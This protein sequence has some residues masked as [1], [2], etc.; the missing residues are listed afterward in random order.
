M[1]LPI[2]S[3]FKSANKTQY[4]L[5]LLLRDEK[6]TAVI[7]EESLG[8]V[9]IISKHEE[10]FATP[11]E[12]ASEE[13]WLD[14]IDKTIS[15]AEEVLPPNIETQKTVFGVKDSW[16]EEKRIK[17]DYLLKLKKVCEALSLT[18]IGFLVISE[19]I[20]HLMQEEEGA[21]VSAVLTEIGK[22]S[23]MI[24]LIRGG[25]VVETSSV[26]RTEEV[27]LAV[28][29]AL[30]SFQ[31][32]VLPSR[33]VIFDGLE[34]EK[35]SQ[36][37]ISHQWSKSLPFLH[38]PQISILPPGFDAKAV[39]FGAAVQMGFTIVGDIVDKTGHEIKTLGHTGPLP[40]TEHPLVE[41]EPSPA[42]S[43]EQKTE[44]EETEP[45]DEV[46]E[47][48]SIAEGAETFGFLTDVDVATVK[49]PPPTIEEP[50]PQTTKHEEKQHAA[51]P[52]SDSLH[53][54]GAK[55]FEE[56]TKEEKQAI[57]THHHE[58]PQPSYQT[59]AGPKG[60]SKIASLLAG[61][62]LPKIALPKGN[63]VFIIPVLLVLLIG[64]GLAYVFLVRAAIT[65]TIKPEVVD[66]TETIVFS[67][68][69]DTDTENHT[70]G[71]KK[72]TVTLD[73]TAS[74]DATGKKDTGNKA[75]GNVTLYNSAETK[76]QLSQGATITS[77]NGL[78]FIVDKEVVVA[79]SSG[80]IFSGIKSGTAQV[81]VTAKAIG[82]EYNLPSNTKFTVAGISSL[83]AKNDTAFSGGSKKQV[84]VVA[85]SDIDKL[86]TGLPKSLEEKAKQEIAK[87]I[88]SDETVLPLFLNTTLAKK[89]FN[90][91]VGEETKTVTLKTQV[92]F[93]GIAYKNENLN[94]IAKSI[95]SDKSSENQAVSEKGVKNTLRSIK[96]KNEDE[97][98]ASLVVNAGLLPKIDTTKV[99]QDVKGKSFADAEEILSQMSQIDGVDIVL[100][101]NIPFLPKLLPRLEKN[102]KVTVQ[103]N[104]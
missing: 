83:A 97:V 28:D 95:I 30:K 19:A 29:A 64:I 25:K 13:E 98:S 10:Y 65:L 76:K 63:S 93:D 48:V 46:K 54:E 50:L 7:I 1:K 86:T 27:T 44:N 12:D 85:K 72:I 22:K 15:R 53:L 99:L 34:T 73:G 49:T 9:K 18:P 36:L 101:P 8:R 84:T 21:P 39:V 20:I 51:A 37:F 66:Q 35:L 102:I 91:D 104:E 5:S 78:D 2:P 57:A 32:D 90:K 70:V 61:I 24:S 88:G 74:T 42:K 58:E 55:T 96:E 43:E 52:I 17:K 26:P 14:I 82:S 79:S 67:T 31:T 56:V 47:T 62:S 11:I 89:S 59:A 92:T 77:S 38:M 69:S 80:D 68:K 81:A 33:V 41:N 4:F 60:P 6:A 23:L 103:T 16:V 87:K 40:K 71:A 75:K 45:I 3:V 94:A 100:I